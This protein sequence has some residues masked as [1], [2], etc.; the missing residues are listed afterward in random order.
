[1]LLLGD[2]ALESSQQMFAVAFDD[3]LYLAPF[4]CV[5]EDIGEVGLYAGVQVDFGLLQDDRRP[6]W[7]VKAEDQYGQNLRDAEAHVGDEHLGP[8]RGLLYPY[9]EMA[10]ALGH[11]HDAKAVN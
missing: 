10:T 3:D 4:P 9:L 8:F 11:G 7:Y 1:M 2:A 6:Y 5:N